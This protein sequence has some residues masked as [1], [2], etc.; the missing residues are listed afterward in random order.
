[1]TFSPSMRYV[2]SGAIK[3]IGVNS[4]R[5]LFIHGKTMVPYVLDN[6][7]TVKNFVFTVLH[8]FLQLVDNSA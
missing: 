1:M 4:S 5:E 2:I 3:K 6:F 8:P 7:I